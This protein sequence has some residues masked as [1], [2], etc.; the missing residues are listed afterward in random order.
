MGCG[1][2]AHGRDTWTGL[3]ASAG[4][5]EYS[6]RARRGRV[7]VRPGPSGPPGTACQAL[8]APC[9]LLQLLPQAQADPS[10]A[11]CAPCGLLQLIPQ[12]QADPFD[13]QADPSDVLV[14]QLALCVPCWLLQ[15]LPQAQADP[16]DVLVPQMLLPFLLWHAIHAS[17]AGGP[18]LCVPANRA[19]T[20]NTARCG[21][22]APCGLLQL[23]LEVT[24]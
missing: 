22:C 15:L 2:P 6:D 20:T 4:A 18:I 12:A 5:R 7:A 17:A 9:G 23:V 14:P 1:P 13:A 19:V 10:D 3:A 16:S 21:L 8:C 11:L 24:D